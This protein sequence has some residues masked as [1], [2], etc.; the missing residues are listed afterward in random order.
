MTGIPAKPALTRDRSKVAEFQAYGTP[1]DGLPDPVARA[2]E[3]L[4]AEVA[5]LRGRVVELEAGQPPVD[6]RSTLRI[7]GT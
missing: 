3:A 1:T 6:A 7:T 4:Q 2:I 5:Q